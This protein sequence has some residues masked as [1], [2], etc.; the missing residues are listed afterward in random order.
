[1]RTLRPETPPRAVGGRYRLPRSIGYCRSS[2]GFV[3]GG[4][5]RLTAGSLPL[6]R[7]YGI[8]WLYVFGSPVTGV[9]AS[10]PVL[11][12]LS[13]GW[14]HAV[15]DACSVVADGVCCAA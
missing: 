15:G 6:M 14:R 2:I 9:S 5:R 10:T 3:P 1:M 7:Y 4:W 12:G 8:L 11:R 13:T